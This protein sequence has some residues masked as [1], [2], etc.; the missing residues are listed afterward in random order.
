LLIRSSD[1][2][3]GLPYNIASLALLATMLAQQREVQSGEIIVCTT[4]EKGSE[5]NAAYL[6]IKRSE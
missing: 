2:F 1:S 4:R 6:S 5:N 3:L